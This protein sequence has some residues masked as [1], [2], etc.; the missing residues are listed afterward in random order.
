MRKATDRSAAAVQKYELIVNDVF[1][2]MDLDSNGSLS[3]SEF[4]E[5]FF[6]M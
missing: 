3:P 6:M 5:G 4:V 2:M 1:K